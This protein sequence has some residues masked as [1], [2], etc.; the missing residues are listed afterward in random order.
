MSSYENRFNSLGWD[1]LYTDDMPDRNERSGGLGKRLMGRLGSYKE[2]AKG[3]SGFFKKTFG[4][5]KK[6][7]EYVERKV[8]D[9]MS[10]FPYVRG[11]ST[12]A[13]IYN[14]YAS[15]AQIAWGIGIEVKEKAREMVRDAVRNYYWYRPRDGG[16]G[17]A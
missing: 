10:I 17:A 5:V 15:R 12:A 11:N 16:L 14:D 1:G 4:A 8:D 3:V 7:F 6:P 9:R 13:R 2:K